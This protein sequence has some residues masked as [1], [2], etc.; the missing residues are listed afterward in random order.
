MGHGRFLGRYAD[1]AVCRVVLAPFTIVKDWHRTGYLA[2]VALGIVAVPVRRV[3]A[4]L[5]DRADVDVMNLRLLHA[6][7]AVVTDDELAGLKA[8]DCHS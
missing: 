8:V 6:R 1:E 2:V 4:R 7:H 5:L 3:V